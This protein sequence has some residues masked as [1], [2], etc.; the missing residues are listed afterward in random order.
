[1]N[2][3]KYSKT[4]ISSAHQGFV[5]PGMAS[6]TLAAFA[7][8]ARKGADMIETD[9]RMTRDGVLIANH[10]PVVHSFDGA[11]HPVTPTIAETD[12]ADLAVLCLTAD[13]RAKNRVPTLASVLSLAY[14]TGM[15][16]NI[17][18]KEGMA[19]AADIARL[20]M[21][22]GMGGRTV[23]ATNGAGMPA[24]RTVLAIDPAARFIDTKRNFPGRPG[25]AAGLSGPVLCLYRG[26][27]R[28][29]HR[30]NPRK[31]LQAGRHFPPHGQLSRRLPPPSG[32]GGIS[33][34]QRFRPNRP[35]NSRPV[36]FII[37]ELRR[38]L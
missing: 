12:Y 26:F 28:R 18:L 33:P 8:A 4:W 21:A 31:R 22:H 1:M 3:R 9:A 37:S 35:G 10:D 7:L 30:R 32:H 29:K 11:G 15:A 34:H 19:H 5:E 20:V 13:G 36:C 23:Y 25:G 2:L 17:D 6:N 38:I 27:F 16:V 24:I 14:F